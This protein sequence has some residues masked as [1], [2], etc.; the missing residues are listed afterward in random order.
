MKR[1]AAKRLIGVRQRR[2]LRQPPGVGQAERRR[3]GLRTRREL[4]MPRSTRAR[5]NGGAQL[6]P[7]SD[8]G[9]SFSAA[10]RSCGSLVQ[11][12]SAAKALTQTNRAATSRHAEAAQGGGCADRPRGGSGRSAACP[13]N[14]GHRRRDGALS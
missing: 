13:W 10:G 9:T 7:A 14:P 5:R 8:A 11:S 3:I 12:S 4:V 6:W 1:L 2:G